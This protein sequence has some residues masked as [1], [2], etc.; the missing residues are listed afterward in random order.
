LLALVVL[1]GCRSHRLAPDDGVD[2]PNVRWPPTAT[3][4]PDAAT[5]APDAGAA[6]THFAND[7]AV[8]PA[9]EASA[10]VDTQSPPDTQRPAD[11]SATDA[12]IDLRPAIEVAP[13]AAVPINACG[14]VP[15]VGEVGVFDVGVGNCSFPVSSLPAF[16]VSVDTPLYA[17]GAACG[18]CLEVGTGD[19]RVVALV[20]DHYPTQP[21]PKG[22]KL[23][24]SRPA[25]MKITG[26]T[27]GLLQLPW[28]RVPCPTTGPI[29]AALKDGS[30]VFYWEVLFQNVTNPIAT[31]EVAAPDGRWVPVKRESYNYFRQASAS[32]LPPR[33]RLTDVHGNVVTTGPLIWPKAP[34]TMPIPIGVQFPPPCVL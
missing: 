26:A 27:T 30:S 22:H 7:A 1:T 19:K 8:P 3:T 13:E 6:D 18:T 2:D 23:S 34:V 31:V 11:A 29:T 33:L 32:G 12:Q 15:L 28:R 9:M 20:V 21:G 25:F 4:R 14:A 16:A 5:P 24:L 10:Q 17:A